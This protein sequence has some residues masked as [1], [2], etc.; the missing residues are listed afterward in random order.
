MFPKAAARIETEIANRK[1]QADR[2]AAFINRAELFADAVRRM[3]TTY[4]PYSL[5]RCNDDGFLALTTD[6]DDAVAWWCDSEQEGFRDDKPW[7]TTANEVFD[8]IWRTANDLWSPAER[9]C[10]ASSLVAKLRESLPESE[11]R[12]VCAVLKVEA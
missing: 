12:D 9:G 6:L 10:D 5:V 8:A 7:P 11:V 3:T 2:H 4:G 1:Q